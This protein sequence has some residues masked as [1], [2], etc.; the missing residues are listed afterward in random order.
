M[1]LEL[2]RMNTN[3]PYL[4]LLNTKESLT[5]TTG[6]SS[7]HSESW[8][9]PQSSHP[10]RKQTAY[11]KVD[12]KHFCKKHQEPN[13]KSST[14]Q[15]HTYKGRSLFIL[16]KRTCIIEHQV[17]SWHLCRWDNT[18]WSILSEDNCWNYLS[19]E[20]NCLTSTVNTL[21]KDG[22]ILQIKCHKI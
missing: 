1:S 3:V 13:T 22:I 21:L 8:Y 18:L 14:K 5:V 20:N 16:L 10:A 2:V 6:P 4:A 12:G 17:D 11:R 19:K 15:N 9:C 7:G